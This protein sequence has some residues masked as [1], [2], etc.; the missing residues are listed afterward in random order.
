MDPTTLLLLAAAFAA[1]CIDSIVGGGGL[2]QLPA[3]L[4][5]LPETPPSMLL[6][7]NKF[8]GLMGTITASVRYARSVRLAWALLI[9]AAVVAFCASFAGSATVSLVSPRLFRPMV[10]VILVFVLGYTLKRKDLGQ[11]HAP[12]AL[13]S[14][15]LGLGLA[16]FAVVG[17]YDGFF[18]PGAGSFL[19]LLFIRYYGFDF[20]NAAASARLVN[21]ATNAASL[22]WFGSHGQALWGLGVAMAVTN[23][24]GAQVG[25][26]LALRRGSHFVRRLFVGIVSVLILKTGWD[27]L[28]LLHH[29]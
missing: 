16:L 19:M 11:Q 27:A 26:R 9:P 29:G 24:A 3:L 25:S 20:L 23:I 21:C 14:V 15:E 12:R 4:A 1:G 10:P 7:T 13:N 6:G 5:A 2:I 28:N 18:G 8:A 17:F 22:C